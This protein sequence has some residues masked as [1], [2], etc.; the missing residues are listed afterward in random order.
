MAKVG[1]SRNN[2]YSLYKTKRF[3]KRTLDTLKQ[4]GINMQNLRVHYNTKRARELEKV[5][6][7]LYAEI[8]VLQELRKLTINE[9]LIE[10]KTYLKNN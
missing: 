3:Q 5:S 10:I 8:K 7:E 1:V 2:I 4:V 9:I 6:N